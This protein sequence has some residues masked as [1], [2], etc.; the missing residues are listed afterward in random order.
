M[1]E[2]QHNG[3]LAVFTPG[4]VAQRFIPSSHKQV[5]TAE[6]QAA[7]QALERLAHNGTLFRHQIA[8]EV[9]YVND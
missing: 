1:V 9:R 7:T 8:N 6:I 5:G 2:S 3:S 4:E